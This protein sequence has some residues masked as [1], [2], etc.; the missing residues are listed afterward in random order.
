MFDDNLSCLLT[1]MG[2]ASCSYFDAHKIQF[3]MSNVN[4]ILLK[5]VLGIVLARHARLLKME[6]FRSGLRSSHHTVFSLWS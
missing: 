1:Y 4:P 5:P 2:R 3:I 6:Q